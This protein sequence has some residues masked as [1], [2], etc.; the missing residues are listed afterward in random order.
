METVVTT[1]A[2]SLL[3]LLEDNTA[4][5]ANGGDTPAQ[6]AAKASLRAK[7]IAYELEADFVEDLRADRDALDDCNSAKYSDNNE[8]VQN[9]SAI[10]TLLDEAQAII[11]RLSPL[12]Q[13]YQRVPPASALPKSQISSILD[14]LTEHGIGVFALF[15]NGES[16]LR[17]DAFKEIRGT[18]HWR[19]TTKIR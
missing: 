3:K 14:M 9:T 1:H 16:C 11:T 19:C 7:F 4:P 8:G 5:V 17:Y 2:D 12:W 10:E 15:K 18:A 13:G 6:L